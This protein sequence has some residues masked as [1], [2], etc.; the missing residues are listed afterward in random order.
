MFGA[1]G[2]FDVLGEER[3]TSELGLFFEKLSFLLNEG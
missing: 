3:I 1:S 2:D